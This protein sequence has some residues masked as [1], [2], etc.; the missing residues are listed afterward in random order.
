M[1]LHL[2]LHLLGNL[3]DVGLKGLLGSTHDGLELIGL[4]QVVLVESDNDIRIFNGNRLVVGVESLELGHL[5]DQ[6]HL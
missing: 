2:C 1:R 4:G 6:W 5:L 3:V